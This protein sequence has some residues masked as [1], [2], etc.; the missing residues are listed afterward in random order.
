MDR[1]PQTA[2]SLRPGH[3]VAVSGVAVPEQE[4]PHSSLLQ[5]QWAEVCVPLLFA[6]FC[7]TAASFD[8]AAAMIRGLC[9]GAIGQDEVVLQA[10]FCRVKALT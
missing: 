1:P 3:S 10:I 4:A 5:A 8:T 6:A 9:T 2:L 7:H